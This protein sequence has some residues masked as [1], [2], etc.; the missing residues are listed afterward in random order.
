MEDYS[1]AGPDPP[2]FDLPQWENYT[3]PPHWEDFN[4]II[5]D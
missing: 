5:N 2:N 3:D 4:Y 1:E